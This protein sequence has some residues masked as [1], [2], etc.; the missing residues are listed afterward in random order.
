MRKKTWA[1]P[2]SV[3]IQYKEINWA[4]GHTWYLFRPIPTFWRSL[5]TFTGILCSWLWLSSLSFS[6]LDSPS[7]VCQKRG[8]TYSMTR[9]STWSD[10]SISLH[11]IF[12]LNQKQ[13]S[14]LWWMP[15]CEGF[16]HEMRTRSLTQFVRYPQ[17]VVS[18][19]FSVDTEELQISRIHVLSLERQ[20]ATCLWHM[21]HKKYLWCHYWK[22]K[23]RWIPR[24]MRL[25]GIVGLSWC[26]RPQGRTTTFPD[27][28]C[29]SP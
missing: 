7:C 25:S 22:C 15:N 27:K 14:N 26:A 16:D 10:Q 17:Q 23:D 29:H 3:I 4:S 6:R 8:G 18:F 2:S 24:L 1:R 19:P 13:I 20:N 28:V 21:I 11:V 5:G 9:T 12:L